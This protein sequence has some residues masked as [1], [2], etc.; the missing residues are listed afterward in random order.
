MIPA[1]TWHSS[2]L[3]LSIC[4]TEINQS[5]NQSIQYVGFVVIAFLSHLLKKNSAYH[6]RDQCR[7]GSA[8]ASSQSNLSLGCFHTYS[9]N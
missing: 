2:V 9:L 6:M 4:D 1:F 5:I 3:M 7:L 8:F